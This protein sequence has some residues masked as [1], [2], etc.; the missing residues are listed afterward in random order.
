MKEYKNPV[1]RGDYRLGTACGMCERCMEIQALGKTTIPYHRPKPDDLTVED[2]EQLAKLQMTLVAQTLRDLHKKKPEAAV[3][4]LTLH[5]NEG[6]EPVHILAAVGAKTVADL[7]AAM[8]I[9]T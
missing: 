3:L 9:Q 1:C 4:A 8:T 2:L 7:R 6:E 5:G